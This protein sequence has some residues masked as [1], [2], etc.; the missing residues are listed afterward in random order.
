MRPIII[1][2][3]EMSDSREVYDSRPNRVLPVFLY[4]CLGLLVVAVVWMCLGE[5]DIAVKANG[6]LRPDEAVRNVVNV[7]AGEVISIHVK[8]GSIVG[9]GDLL[10]VIGHEEL[11][12]QKEFYGEQIAL[13][14]ARITELETYLRSI[15]E[16]I[17]CFAN[18]KGE[19]AVRYKSFQIQLDAMRS[20][21]MA[22]GVKKTSVYEGGAEYSAVSKYK[23][24]EE[25][26]TLQCM[27]AHKESLRQG[28]IKLME[29]EEAIE[30]CYVKAPCA[31]VVNL[32]REPVMGERM[33]A[34]AEVCSILPKE[35]NSFK[36]VLCVDNVD[37][38]KLEPGMEVKL[39]VYS[40]PSTEYGY[41]Y[42]TLIT[43]SEDVRVDSGSGRMYYQA[44]ASVDAEKF[45]D[46]KGR[47][48]PLKV[49]M[50]CEAKVLTGE[51]KIIKFVLEKLN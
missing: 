30:A 24:D 36:C 11:L 17:D 41:M 6:M 9:E 29:V 42:G 21:L 37:V 22:S 27:N 2:M 45:V 47:P 8:D 40:H 23:Y 10:Y 12:R 50:A 19:Y 3:N 32:L 20:E 14:T 26:V 49:G 13:Y 35:K 46:E 4:T 39:N 16:E 31:G 7:T 15:K 5:I 38:G 18:I 1:N 34:G 48:I 25:V 33:A 28:K 51:K 43:V 44:E